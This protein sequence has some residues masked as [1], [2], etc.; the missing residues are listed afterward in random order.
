M[1]P[2]VTQSCYTRG[3]RALSLCNH[4]QRRGSSGNYYFRVRIPSDLLEA[5][6]PKKE[7]TFSLKTKDPKEAK[8]RCR[9]EAVRIDQEFEEHR[10]RLKH[11]QELVAFSATSYQEDSSPAAPLTDLDSIPDY[12][13][14]RLAV[15]YLHEVLAHDE[16]ERTSGSTEMARKEWEENQE[17]LRQLHEQKGIPFTPEA[18]PAQGAGLSSSVIQRKRERARLFLSAGGSYLAS[19]DTSIIH[20]RA[21]A[22]LGAHGL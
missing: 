16:Q 22:F 17:F 14:D 21:L 13:L 18:F 3:M 20:D 4:L 7:L 19:G 15:L 11:E 12:E 6:A 8:A 10:R 2:S 1:L 5:Y 9:V